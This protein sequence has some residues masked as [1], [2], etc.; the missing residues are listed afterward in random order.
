MD[1]NSDN[2]IGNEEASATMLEGKENWRNLGKS[3]TFGN[4]PWITVYF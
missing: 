4:F 2:E 3:M 1:E